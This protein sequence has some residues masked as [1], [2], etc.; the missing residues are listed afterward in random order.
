MN[1]CRSEHNRIEQR[2]KRQVLDVR[3]DS[4]RAPD[5]R[6]HLGAVI[7]CG[8]FVAQFQQGVGNSANAGPEL[9]NGPTC[10][11]CR[12][13]DRRIQSS[14]QELPELDR[15]PVKGSRAGP[16]PSKAHLGCHRSYFLEFSAHWWQYAVRATRPGKS[17]V[18][19]STRGVYRT[20][21]GRMEPNG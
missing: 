11:N 20:A 4:V 9:E 15:A 6:Q 19:K 21:R 13:D 7:D 10:R 8:D 2:T 17:A 1:Q 14:R 3:Q 5:F 16:P 12:G 18:W